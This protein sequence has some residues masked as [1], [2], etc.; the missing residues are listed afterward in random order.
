M[1]KPKLSVVLAT[2]NEE[3]NIGACLDSI[4]NIADEIIIVDESSTDRTRE[5]ARSYK[6]K[7]YKT[8]HEPIFHITKQKAIDL[9]T[10]DWIL[11]LDADERVSGKLAQEIISTLQMTNDEISKKKLDPSKGIL[12]LRHQKLIEERE[13][14]LGIKTGEVVAFFIP[15][16]NYFIGK[17][18]I[19]AGVYPD[20]VIRLFKKGKAYLP[21]K[22]VHEQMVIKGEVRWLEHDLEHHDSPTLRKYIMRLN[23]Y[24]DLHA[25]NLYNERISKNLATFLN[26]SIFKPS[27]IFLKLYFRHKGFMDGIRG[28]LWSFFS[29][30]HFP[31]SY[32][33]YLTGGYK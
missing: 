8:K 6:A 25:L 12:F 19:H 31:I 22:S 29:A 33:K 23:R 24:T 1:N 26:Y 15:R 13:G 30:M 10:G 7:V 17:P 32:Y 28:F 14:R 5:I 18:L 3:K 11:Q 21:A 20:G 4:K 9:A 2:Y 27:Y 16:V